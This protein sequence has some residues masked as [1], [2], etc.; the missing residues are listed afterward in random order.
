MANR[1][2]I[3]ISAL[4]VVLALSL[5]AW[6]LS[7]RSAMEI[8]LLEKYQG[9]LRSYAAARGG[10]SRVMDLM[11]KSPAKKDTLYSA[12]I[13]IPSGKVP[14]DIFSHMDVGRRAYAMV[15]WPAGGLGEQDGKP[16]LVYGLQDEQGKININAINENNYQILSALFELKGLSR[17]QADGMAL[18]MVHFIATGDQRAGAG[19]L[20]D[21]DWRPVLKPKNRPYDHLFELLEIPGMTGKLFDQIKDDVTV[22]G[23]S[24]NGLSVNMDTANDDVVQALANAAA[25]LDPSSGADAI[26]R[27]AR[28]VRDGADGKPFTED[29]GTGIFSADARHWP[30]ALRQINSEFFRARVVGIDAGTGARTVIE[31]VIRRPPGLAKNQ[32]VGWHRD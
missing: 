20:A 14:Q 9:K 28:G 25:R 6:G 12:G 16:R 8:F 24:Q 13:D 31:A 21:G 7:R 18:A 30:P 29:D 1:G 22:Y 17:T 11:D 27:Q 23:E 3:L 2:V 4:W 15:Q 19:W 32:I 10:I 5:I 26:V